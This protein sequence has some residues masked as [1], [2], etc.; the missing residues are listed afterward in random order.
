MKI[1]TRDFGPMELDETQAIEFSSPVF[2]FEDLRRYV[3]LS[4]DETGPG[5]MW[6]QSIENPDVCFILLDPVDLGLE[7]YPEIHKDTAR[8]LE[9]TGAPIVRLIAVVPQQFKDT[10]VN[11]K[12][13][14]IINPV[15]QKAAQVILEQDYPIRMRIF[16][17]EETG[18]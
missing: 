8:E 14:V 16:G 7:Y 15:N 5:L 17:E 11:L 18:C 1:L 4:D 12:S 9:L 10:T 2:G 13:P 6:L 3:L